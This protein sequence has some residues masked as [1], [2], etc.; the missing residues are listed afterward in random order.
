MKTIL[1]IAFTVS[2]FFSLAQNNKNTIAPAD[3]VNGVKSKQINFEVKTTEA[4]FNGG[5]DSIC[6]YVLAKLVFPEA[7]MKAQLIGKIKVAYD[8]T[9]EGKVE[10]VKLFSGVGY[11][12]DEQVMKLLLNLKYKPAEAQGTPY[13]SQQILTIPIAYSYFSE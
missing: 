3:S 13:T 5:I 7:A 8:V 11:G 10:N 9:G 2:C 1:C 6:R 12:I 4:V